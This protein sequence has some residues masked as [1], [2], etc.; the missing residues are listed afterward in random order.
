MSWTAGVKFPSGAR[1]SVL[2][3]QT[4]SGAH[5]APYPMHAGALTRGKK[6]PVREADHSPPSNAEV[7]NNRATSTPPPPNMFSLH[8]V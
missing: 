6:Q 8:S 3:V 2:R 5:T 1:F 7:K 4:G